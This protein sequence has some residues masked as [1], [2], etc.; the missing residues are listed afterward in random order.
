M[1]VVSTGLQEEGEVYVFQGKSITKSRDRS[2]YTQGNPK[3]GKG[4][5]NIDLL[6]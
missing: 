6:I 2:L 3:A 5:Q 1:M 4:T